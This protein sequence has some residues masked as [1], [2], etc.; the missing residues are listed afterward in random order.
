[1]SWKYV[2]T[3]TLNSEQQRKT[4]QVKGSDIEN[5]IWSLIIVG[6]VL[7]ISILDNF[8]IFSALYFSLIRILIFSSVSK[9]EAV[10]LEN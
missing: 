10:I 4:L 6:T 3:E 7:N 2:G 9:F 8:R 1:M 5:S